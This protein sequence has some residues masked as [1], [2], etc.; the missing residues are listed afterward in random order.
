MTERRFRFTTDQG[1]HI[2]FRMSDDPPPRVR[3]EDPDS[4]HFE[5][6]VG[7]RLEAHYGW[8]SNEHAEALIGRL[9]SLG[10]VE[11]SK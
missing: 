11:V 9:L 1:H 5:V 8:T 6:W 7:G 4:K 2:E 3:V 10:A